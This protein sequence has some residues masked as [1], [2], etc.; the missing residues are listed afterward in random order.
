MIADEVPYRGRVELLRSADC[1]CLELRGDMHQGLFG[2]VEM[3]MQ[4]GKGDRRV[5]GMFGSAPQRGHQPR[6]AGD[7][8]ALGCGIAVTCE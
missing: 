4:P 8:L 3:G 2:L 6:S 7:G 5:T 1:P